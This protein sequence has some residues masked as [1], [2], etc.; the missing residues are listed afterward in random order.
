M[1]YY[2]YQLREWWHTKLPQWAAHKLPRRIAFFAYVRVHAHATQSPGLTDR[3]PYE[4]DWHEAMEA[5]DS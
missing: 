1:N 3:T 5:W 4:I 2:W